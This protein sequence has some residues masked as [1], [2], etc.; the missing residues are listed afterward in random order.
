MTGGGGRAL[1]NNIL[2]RNEG[3]GIEQWER[4]NYLTAATEG[5]AYHTRKSEAGL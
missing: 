2:E 3:S 1:G 5:S 4:L